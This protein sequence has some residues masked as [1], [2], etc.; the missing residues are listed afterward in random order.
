MFLFKD[1]FGDIRSLHTFGST[2]YCMRSTDPLQ[3]I[4]MCSYMINTK[5][6]CPTWQDGVTEY[7][8]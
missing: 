6:E 8:S 1:V 7:G 3:W 4:L 5:H 2:S